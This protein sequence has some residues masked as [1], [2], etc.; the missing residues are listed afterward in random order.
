MGHTLLPCAQGAAGQKMREDIIAK[1]E[2]WQEPPPA[3]TVKPLPRPDE[4]EVR[5]RASMSVL[6]GGGGGFWPAGQVLESVW[7]SVLST[8]KACT[9]PGV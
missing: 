5:G 2:K 3:K 7:L 9:Q 6:L 8:F 4:K 1:I